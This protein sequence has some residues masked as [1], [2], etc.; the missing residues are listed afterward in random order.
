MA[1]HPHASIGATLGRG[2]PRPLRPQSTGRGV[3]ELLSVDSQS[4]D[5][6]V[7]PAHWL[8]SPGGDVDDLGGFDLLAVTGL[9]T[10]PG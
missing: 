4:Q 3:I 9:A 2:P 6:V 10:A 5:R 8:L 1:G 7:R